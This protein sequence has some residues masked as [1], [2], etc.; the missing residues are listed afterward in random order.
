[1]QQEIEVMRVLRVPPRGE[2]VVEVGGN[3]YIKLA[4]LP[5]ARL[6]QLLLTAVGELITFVG[7][8][9]ELEKAGVAPAKNA[10]QPNAAPAPIQAPP[11]APEEKFVA[12]MESDL[13]SMKN[14]PS[15]KRRPTL[16]GVKLKPAAEKA[17]V[18]IVA[19]IDAILQTYITADPVLAQRSIHLIDGQTGGVK[20]EIDGQI[21]ER[22][23]QISDTHIQQVIKRALKTWESS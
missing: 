22:P 5:D 4:D 6:R 19:Q 14:A 17:S 15:G 11:M 16:P 2:L 9:P 13:E 3:R 8:Y 23:S 10:P 7:G 12:Q 21:Y 18:S 20:I 1:M